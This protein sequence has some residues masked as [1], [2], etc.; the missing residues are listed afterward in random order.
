[1]ATT[2]DTAGDAPAGAAQPIRTILRPAGPADR[3]LLPQRR[4][5]EVGHGDHRHRAHGLRARAPDRQPQAVPLARR[6]STSTARRCAT[7]PAT[8]CPR[9]WLLWGV[10]IGLIAAFVFHIH[11]AYGLTMINR[12]A[13]PGATLPVEARLRRRRLR[14]AHDALDRHHRRSCSSSSTSPTSRGARRTPSS[15]AAIRT[16]TSCTACSGRPSR[17]CTSSRCSP[18]AFHLYHGGWSHVP[19]HGHQQPALQQGAPLASRS[20]SPVSSSIGQPELPD[21]G[22]SP[23]GRARV[24][25]HDPDDRSRV[26]GASTMTLDSKHPRRPARGEVGQPQ[27]RHQARQPREQAPLRHHRRRHRPGRRVGGGV[28]SAELG[29]NVKVVTFHDSPRRAHSIA[30]QGGI[31]AA[32]NYKN[33]GDSIYRLFYDTIKGGDYRSREANVYRLAQ[34]SVDIIDQCVAQ[35]VPFAREYGGLLDN[36]SL[37]RRAGVAHVLRAGPDRP[38][39]AARR[40]P[41][42]DAPGALGTASSCY[43]RTE[44]LDLVVKD[45]RGRGHRVPRPQHRRGVLDVRRTPS[46]SRPAATAT[47]STCRRTP[48]TPTSPRPGA[49]PRRARTSPTRATRRSTR[50]ASRRA[51]SSSRSSR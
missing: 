13:R 30:A 5:Q 7:C 10:R 50:R 8:C 26:N 49:P 32:K 37:R 38:A 35:G 14:V 1:M 18:S 45:G 11:A 40:V 46:C 12:K 33:D 21:R 3:A 34:V 39:A 23:L 24:P 44:M 22:A 29:Y 28:A 51:T 2:H 36:R 19:E 43:P 41:G 9:T 20:G 16:T 17:S 15:C 25:A 47:P 42:A 27:V 31:N 4:R 48:R 6:R